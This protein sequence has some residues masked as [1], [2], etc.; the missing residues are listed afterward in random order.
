MGEYKQTQPKLIII[1]SPQLKFADL[2]YIRNTDKSIELELFVAGKAIE[3]ITIN[4]LICMSKG[5]MSKS[6][7]NEDYLSRY[8][9]DELL[10]DVLLGQPIFELKNRVK[11]SD[12][13]IQ[14]IVDEHLDITYKVEANQIYF[15]DRKNRILIKI[16]DIK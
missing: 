4:H 15:K 5:C 12:G 1:K 13:F 3:K 9:D 11:T 10:Q 14:K 6:G 16:K 7:F 8:Y 2:G